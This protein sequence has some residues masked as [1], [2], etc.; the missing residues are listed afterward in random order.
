MNVPQDAKL[1]L[2]RAKNSFRRLEREA[3]SDKLTLAQKIAAKEKAT[4]AGRILRKLRM[5]IFDLED[6]LVAKQQ[7][8]NETLS[9]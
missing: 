3:K 7:K 1:Q 9:A 4:E 2:D 6:M 5:A 8:A